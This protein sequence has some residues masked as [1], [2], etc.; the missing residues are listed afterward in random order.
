MPKRTH[1]DEIG[2]V[3]EKSV[4][5]IFTEQLRWS[6][7][8]FG[9]KRAGIDGEV[10]IVEDGD[11]TGRLLGVQV[12]T[13]PSYFSR[14]SSD[15]IV[16]DGDKDELDY[17][18]RYAL[19]VVLVLVDPTGGVAYWAGITKDTVE[20]TGKRWKIVVSYA[21]KLTAD[22]RDALAQLAEGS[23]STQRLRQLSMHKGLMTFLA[24]GGSIR[25]TGTVWTNKLVPRM[26]MY[27]H[28]S[29]VTGP[30]GDHFE[31]AVPWAGGWP[32]EFLERR[33]PWADVTVTVNGHEDEDD[34]R[35]ALLEGLDGDASDLGWED[36]LGE[37]NIEGWEFKASLGLG[38]LGRSFL[39][40]DSFLEDAE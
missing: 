10:E 1:S 27:L 13:G 24:G 15:G 34:L 26:S 9:N 4:D 23:P 35:E 30:M 20:I 21:Q 29:D 25:I 8:S 37:V 39:R 12:R 5:L 31:W 33:F 36:L 38:E 7:H 17:W 19:P 6:Y 18:L 2:E 28:F 3:G 14:T 32:S 16:Y 11:Y 22:A 40:V